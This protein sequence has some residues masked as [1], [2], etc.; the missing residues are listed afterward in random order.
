MPSHTFTRLGYWQDSIE[1]NILSADAAR[2]ANAI[3]EELH[4]QGLSDLCLPAERQDA[5]ARRIVESLPE[6]RPGAVN[7]HAGGA[8]PPAGAFAVAAIQA[9]YVL[10]RGAWADAARLEPRTTHSRT[11]TR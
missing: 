4:A 6:I 8:P 1:T 2:K 10:E 3:G 11:P 9:R 7:G 5:A